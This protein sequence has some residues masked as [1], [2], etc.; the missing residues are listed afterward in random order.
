M[1]IPNREQNSVTFGRDIINRVNQD[2]RSGMI[3]NDLAGKMQCLAS[4]CDTIQRV[5]ESENC[6]GN[7]MGTLLRQ[8]ILA[9]ATS[10]AVAVDRESGIWFSADIAIA[11]N[12]SS[13]TNFCNVPSWNALDAAF[14]ATDVPHFI[15]HPGGSSKG[16]SLAFRFDFDADGLWGYR[17][18]QWSQSE[19][20]SF[21]PNMSSI[22]HLHLYS[23]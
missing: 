11:T 19:L 23:F 5:R 20:T 15:T 14:L 17:V 7:L 6:A 21:C 13:L 2:V 22:Y 8:F 9:G 3:Q 12:Q 1:Y 4:L 16:E 10:V 18:P